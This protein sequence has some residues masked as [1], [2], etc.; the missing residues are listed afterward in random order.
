MLKKNSFTCLPEF[1]K[2]HLSPLED[3]YCNVRNV[4]RHCMTNMIKR[5]ISHVKLLDIQHFLHSLCIF[6][7]AP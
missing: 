1:V 6:D 4:F 5:K 3:M 2:M 7:N